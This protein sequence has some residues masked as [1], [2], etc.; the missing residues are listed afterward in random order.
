MANTIAICDMEEMYVY[1]LT[2]FIQQKK[3]TCVDI[4]AFNNSS[5]LELFLEKTSIC[6]LVI[7]EEMLTKKIKEAGIRQIILINE[8]GVIKDKEYLNLYKY[9]P[10]ESLMKVILKEYVKIAGEN[11]RKINGKETKIIGIYSPVGRC[12]QTSFSLV[13]GQLLAKKKRTLYINFESFS[14]FRKLMQ[15]EY[16]SDLLDLMYFMNS[17]NEKFLYKLSEITEKIGDLDYIPPAMSFLDLAEVEGG[18]WKTFLLEIASGTEYEVIILDLS[19]QVRGLFDLL[20]ECQHIYTITRKDGMALAKI[21]QYEKILTFC[22]QKNILEKT[23]K[24]VLPIFK[25]L[26]ERIE[27][28]PYSLLAEYVGGVMREDAL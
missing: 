15:R 2:D 21:D 3:N 25:E 11:T 19:D 17:G 18:D 26:P 20:Q 7:A 9:Q 27:K 12:L 22:D 8:D 16:E 14:G 4:L 5:K 1:K 13:L 10:A 6:V 23:R 24:C 28:L